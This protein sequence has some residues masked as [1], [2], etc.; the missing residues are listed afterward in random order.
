ML[1][2]TSEGTNWSNKYKYIG[3]CSVCG[4]AV[5]LDTCAGYGLENCLAHM[6]VRLVQEV[7]EKTGLGSKTVEGWVQVPGVSETGNQG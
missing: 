7:E 2:A 1:S 6:Q 3:G 4:D 5:R